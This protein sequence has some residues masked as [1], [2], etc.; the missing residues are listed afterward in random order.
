MQALSPIGTGLKGLGAVAPV[1]TLAGVAAL[2]LFGQPLWAQSILTT[3]R[4]TGEVGLETAGLWLGLPQQLGARRLDA[5]Q[6]FQVRLRG[7]VYDG[8]LLGF[9]L[10]LRPQWRQTSLSGT[11]ELGDR[12]ASQ[13]GLDAGLDFLPGG[14]FTASLSAV[15]TANVLRRE[16]G[17]ETHQR[18]SEIGGRLGYQNRYFPLEFQ[19]RSRSQDDYWLTG[20]QQWRSQLLSLGTIRLSAANRKTGL[21]VEHNTADDRLTRIAYGY[22]RGELRHGMGWGKGSRLTSRGEY[23]N[24]SGP[25]SYALLSWSEGV[26]LQHTRAISSDYRFA[27]SS[28]RSPGSRVGNRFGELAL[29]YRVLRGLTMEAGA[30]DRWTSL[31]GAQQNLFQLRSAID[32]RQRLPANVMLSAALSAGYERNRL[33]PSEDGWGTVVD[34][35]YV[36]DASGRLSL[37]NPQVDLASVVVGN[38]DRTL[39][40]QAG[41]DYQLVP[42]GAFVELLVVP[43]GRAAPGDTL[44][45]SYR[46]RLFSP[47]RT[48][49]FI[50]GGGASLI[51]LGFEVYHRRT[52][53]SVRETDPAYG[54]TANLAAAW[55]GDFAETSS[56]ARFS[57]MTS[58]G[59]LDVGIDRQRRELASHGT[60]TWQVRGSVSARPLGPVRASAG[61]S[62]SRT[63]SDASG[64]VTVMAANSALTLLPAPSLLLRASVA[65]WRWTQ[66]G[67][68]SGQFAGGGLD[69][70]WTVGMLRVEAHYSRN[71]W[72]DGLG[73][74]DDRLS[75]RAVRA[76]Q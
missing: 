22:T 26:H 45:V 50:G 11:T 27:T 14:P 65:G 62:G 49:A 69:A 43:G 36:V 37:T 20:P 1:R 31:T 58:A 59:M 6:W 40:Y 3:E 17:T 71:W 18:V 35:R 57:G 44:F 52:L 24:R 29:N 7:A 47:F 39:V 2:L 61:A 38:A 34:E 5:W 42:A 70:E 41:L 74:T 63:T 68:P 76:F 16:F 55:L 21:V 23:F 51:V 4:P 53:R 13:W 72:R 48:G 9:R 25:G 19:F 15:R 60:T 28:L 54:A 10:G 30:S 66:D 33:E 64:P 73:R 56:G 46:Y 75:I 12:G 67:V 8:R 32:Y